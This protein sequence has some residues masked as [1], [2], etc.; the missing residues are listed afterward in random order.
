M[1]T[2]VR[3]LQD[4]FAKPRNAHAARLGSG[5]LLVALVAGLFWIAVA[6]G[7]TQLGSPMGMALAGSGVAAL[8]TALPALFVRRISAH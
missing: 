5:T 7:G 6:Q 4:F 1:N 8:A 3:T 2:A